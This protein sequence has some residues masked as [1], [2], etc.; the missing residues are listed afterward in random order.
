MRPM[1]KCFG[2]LLAVSLALF[3]GLFFG[4][5]YP[6]IVRHGWPL[7][8]CRVLSAE[9]A[10]R[11][12]CE[13]SCSTG[14]C[15]MDIARVHVLRTLLRVPRSQVV[16]AMEAITAVL[17]AARRASL[18]PRAAPEILQRAVNLAPPTRKHSPLHCEHRP[19]KYNQSSRCNCYCCSSTSDLYCTL[20]CP[21]CY[22]VDLQLLYS[23]RDGEPHNVSYVQDFSKDV[24]SADSFL[25]RHLANS[26]S[27]CNYNPKDESQV[28]FDV[29]FTPWKWAIT[30]IFGIL[31]LLRG[32]QPIRVLPPR[33]PLLDPGA[34]GIH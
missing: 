29:S 3:F 10:T 6:E 13:T 15:Q 4:L 11:Y 12:C 21:I 34:R 24:N 1:Y 22:K 19:S 14:S 16:F 9:I 33:P 25:N 18:V 30:A 8:R 5:N 26:T 17:P 7:A 27:F 28:L 32:P 23:S 2:L 20:S 31:P